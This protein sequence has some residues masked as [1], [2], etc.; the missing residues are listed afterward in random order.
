MRRRDFLRAAGLTVA[1]GSLPG[2]AFA[3]ADTDARLVV[4][5]LR[6]AMD[7]LALA[8]PYGDGN[9]AGLR[10]ELALPAPGQSG[11]L[12]KLDGMFGLHPAMSGLHRDFRNKDALLIHAVASPYRERSHFDGQD[13]L[14]TGGAQTGTTRDGWLNRAIAPLGGSLG[15]ETA[16]AMAENTPLILRGSHSVTSWS[17]SRLPNA[18]AATIA[19]LQDLYADDEFFAT[20]LAQALKSQDIAMSSGEADRT[21][22]R[23]GDAKYLKSLLESTA[24]FL[25]ADDGPRVAVLETS[26]WDTHSNQGASNGAMA[27]RLAS[28]DDG[29]GALRTGLGENWD[30]TVVAIVTEFGRTA[31]VNG[32]RGTDHGTASAAILVGGAVNGGR[33]I[34]DWPGLSK[35]NL[36]QG[37]DLYP[38]TDLRSVFKGVLSDHLALDEVLLEKS[39]FPESRAA[40]GMQG[41]I[42]V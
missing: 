10:G 7:G 38:T 27:N 2:A 20:R 15:R 32:T 19:R 26:G 1:A 17:P 37:R 12:L 42:R 35:A 14:E 5:L 34:A 31:A 6:G 8:A 3:R 28:L 13:L 11:G 9:Y 41:L 29:L 36:Y 22:G 30:S 21:G 39:V 16:I 25:S 40:Q 18:S 23:G 4:I 24:G 33:V